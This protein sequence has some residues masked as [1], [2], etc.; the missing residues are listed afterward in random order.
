MSGTATDE[1][2]QNRMQQRYLLWYESSRGPQFGYAVHH[3]EA[4]AQVDAALFRSD[5]YPTR[6]VKVTIVDGQPKAEWIS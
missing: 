2:P 6:I 1:Q 4:A 5:G 3:T